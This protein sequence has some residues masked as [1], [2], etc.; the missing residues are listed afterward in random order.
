MAELVAPV[1]E[2]FNQDMAAEMLPA[3]QLLNLELTPT[4]AVKKFIAG[5]QRSGRPVRAVTVVD[6]TV[7]LDENEGSNLLD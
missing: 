2:D 1:L 6:K 3:L 4:L 5:R 7:H